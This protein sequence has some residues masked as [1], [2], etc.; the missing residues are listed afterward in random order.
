MIKLTEG[1][2]KVNKDHQGALVDMGI[3]ESDR[4]YN[5]VDI[6]DDAVHG[7]VHGLMTDALSGLVDQIVAFA[8]S[9]GTD[10][11]FIRAGIEANIADFNLCAGSGYSTARKS[12]IIAEKYDDLVEQGI[13]EPTVDL[14]LPPKKGTTSSPKAETVGSLTL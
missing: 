10:G 14:F 13:E 3:L 1:T 8:E 4:K 9:N 6:T 12:A 7:K 11:E 5:K 2:V